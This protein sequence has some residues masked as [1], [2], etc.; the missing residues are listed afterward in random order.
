MRILWAKSGGFLPLDNGG[1]IRSF[2]IA[3]ELARRHEVT[4]FTFYPELTPD[5]HM[6]LGEPFAQIERVSLNIPER[7]SIRDMLAYAANAVTRRPYQMRKYCRP[8]V[9]RR[10]R[11]FLYHKK[12][13]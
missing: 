1:K 7:A 5:P 3:R 11:E 13:E 9:G 2:N 10:L 4:L 8:H 12:H 6:E